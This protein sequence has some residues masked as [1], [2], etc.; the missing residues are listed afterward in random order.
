MTILKKKKNKKKTK[1]KH[2]GKAKGRL[3]ASSILK[4]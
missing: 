2:V 4:K 1:K 3:S